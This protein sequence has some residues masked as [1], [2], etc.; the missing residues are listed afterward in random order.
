M[1]N[2]NVMLK[3]IEWFGIK[4]GVVSSFIAV[5]LL[6]VF[7]STMLLKLKNFKRVFSIILEDCV[8]EID[9]LLLAVLIVLGIFF[10][11]AGG[12]SSIL[13]VIFTL[14]CYLTV[15]IFTYSLVKKRSIVNTIFLCIFVPKFILKYLL[16]WIEG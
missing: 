1:F 16:K 9:A 13:G 11:F 8:S 2:I 6:G 15:Y 7:I 4:L 10:P 14:Y 12:L 3:L 5:F